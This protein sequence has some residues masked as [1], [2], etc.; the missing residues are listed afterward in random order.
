MAVDA[1]PGLGV[2][3]N[4]GPSEIQAIAT[5]L[6]DQVSY[7]DVASQ[8]A[9][10]AGDGLVEPGQGNCWQTDVGRTRAARRE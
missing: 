5:A 6:G 3:Y 4:R 10:L 8:L 2:L 7:A 1:G 9:A